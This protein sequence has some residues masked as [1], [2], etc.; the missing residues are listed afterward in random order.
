MKISN[1]V[2]LLFTIIFCSITF[3]SA[4][5]L[6]LKIITSK[7]LD[8]TNLYNRPVSL[9]SFN[10]PNNFMRHRNYELW[11][12][13]GV[14]ELFQK[15]ASFFVRSA[16]NGKKGFISLESVNYPGHFI[17]H[18]NW[19]LSIAQGCDDL[20]YNDASFQLILSKIGHPNYVSLESSNY[21]GHFIR[22]QGGRCKISKDDGSDLFKE[23]A[24]W[25]L[26]RALY[27]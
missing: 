23:D 27:L 20:F 19:L 7:Y 18:S 2:L 15:D 1:S 21:P 16:L 4:I 9:K 22:H 12:E 5:S 8:P 10:Y 11:K 3:S 25:Q 6:K 17:R 13:K 24:S 14:W 26:T